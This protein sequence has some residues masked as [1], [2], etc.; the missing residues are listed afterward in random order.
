MTWFTFLTGL[1]IFGIGAGCK[2]LIPLREWQA[3]LPLVM[4]LGFLTLAEGMRSQVKKRR[5]FAFLAIVWSIVVI[6]TMLPVAREGLKAWDQE[7]EARPMRSELV[8]EHASVLAVSALYLLVSTVV[9]LRRK[10]EDMTKL[11]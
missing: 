3:L 5:L 4:G 8:M 10:P 2:F 11:N 7:A 1:I 9:F 6:V